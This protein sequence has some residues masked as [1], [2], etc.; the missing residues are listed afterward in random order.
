MTIALLLRLW[1]ETVIIVLLALLA[2]SAF[3]YSERGNKIE[4]IKSEY[5]LESAQIAAEYESKARQIEREN[6]ERTITAVNEYKAR[7]QAILA[8]NADARNA[9]NSLSDTIDKLADKAKADA[10]FRDRYLTTSNQ[11]FKECIGEY[12]KMGEVAS[13]LSNDLRLITEANKR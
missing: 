3:L 12:S 8:D 5:K 11:L 1:R 13:R 4:R 10:S 9:V 2:I 6:Y 7:E